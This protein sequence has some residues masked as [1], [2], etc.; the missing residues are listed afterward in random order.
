MAFN[1]EDKMKWSELAPSLQ[2]KFIELEDAIKDQN[3]SYTQESSDIRWTVGDTPP[4]NPK[5]NAE[6]WFDTKYKVLRAFA[7]NNWE[8]TRAAWYG[9][10]SSGITPPPTTDDPTPDPDIPEYEPQEYTYTYL[11]HTESQNSITHEYNADIC[12]IEADGSQNVRYIFQG[13]NSKYHIVIN[14]D[15]LTNASG[16]VVCYLLGVTGSTDVPVELGSAHLW[17]VDKGVGNIDIEEGVED[18]GW[19]IFDTDSPGRM[20][21]KINPGDKPNDTTFQSTYFPADFPYRYPIASWTGG[22][23]TVPPA[24]ARNYPTISGSFSINIEV[25]STY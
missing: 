23:G 21:V 10:D 22:A 2:D 20:V 15:S 3:V 17:K 1:L 12:T 5:N 24:P 18:R 9:G 14:V 6:M 25:K 7:Q 16:Q 8:F 4:F 13:T 19:C 11:T